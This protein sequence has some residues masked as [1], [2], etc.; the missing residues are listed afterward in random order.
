MAIKG[1]HKRSCGDGTVL[2]LDCISVNILAVIFYQSFARCYHWG[3]LIK[4]TQ[5]L[6]VLLLTDAC[7]SAI[8]SK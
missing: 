4:N 6:P 8:I 3:K 5:I 1:Q 2:Y 7:E